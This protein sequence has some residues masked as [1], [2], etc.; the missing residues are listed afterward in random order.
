MLNCYLE[1]NNSTQ[2]VKYDKILDIVSIT[3]TIDK[4][5]NIDILGTFV[6]ISGSTFG[7]KIPTIHRRQEEQKKNHSQH[8]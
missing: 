7:A 2:L 8:N 5:L 6:D 1:L 3:G 4:D